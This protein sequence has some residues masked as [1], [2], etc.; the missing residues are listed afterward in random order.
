M[1]LLLTVTAKFMHKETGNPV[2]GVSFLAKL[3]DKDIFEDDFLG[4]CEPDENGQVSFTFNPEIFADLDSLME[5]E[6]DLYCVLFEDSKLIFRTKLIPDLAIPQNAD[7]N[8]NSGQ[9]YD[10]GT[11]IV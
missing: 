6:P 9:T 2:R 4:E 7:F 5:K 8:A 3:Y 11:F 10:L 1:E